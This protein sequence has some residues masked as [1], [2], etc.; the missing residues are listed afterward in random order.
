MESGPARK[1]QRAKRWSF[2]AN[3]PGRKGGGKHLIEVIIIL[4]AIA[5]NN[6]GVFITTWVKS[7][8][9]GMV[10]AFVTC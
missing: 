6:S 2:V 1:E 4:V 10:G 3:V 7:C 8:Q 5:I 9:P